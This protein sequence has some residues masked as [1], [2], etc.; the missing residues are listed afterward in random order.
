MSEEIGE[1]IVKLGFVRPAQMISRLTSPSV[2]L[3]TRVREGWYP[4]RRS[5][6]TAI[7]NV[8]IVSGNVKRGT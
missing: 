2:R 5:A 8:E 7:L 1:E 6:S 3:R 4:E